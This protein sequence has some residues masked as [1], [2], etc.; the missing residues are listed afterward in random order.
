MFCHFNDSSLLILKVV[1]VVRNFI[2]RLWQ[3][4]NLKTR[5]F[6][7]IIVTV[8][9]TVTVTVIDYWL[10][11]II[12]DYW[13]LIIHYSLLIIIVAVAVVIVIVI[14]IVRAFL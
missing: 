9:V 2:L 14:V 10:F 7:V 12:I 11:I 13:L 8:I 5:K 1:A 4:E 3:F 6:I